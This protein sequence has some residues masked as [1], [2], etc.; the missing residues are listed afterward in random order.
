[1]LPEALA[2][3]PRIIAVGFYFG[4]DLFDA[5]ILGRRKPT[6][7]GLSNLVQQAAARE[8]EE[9]L[10]QKAARL[11]GRSR[12][13]TRIRKWLGEHVMSARCEST[14]PVDCRRIIIASTA[15]SRR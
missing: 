7:P 2:L 9:P 10:E 13:Q 11:F 14:S 1:L 6:L 12:E 4:N 3:Q 15:R 5:F 8:K